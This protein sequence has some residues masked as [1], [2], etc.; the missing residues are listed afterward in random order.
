M[1]S[2]INNYEDSLACNL[3]CAILLLAYLYGMIVEKFISF[4]YSVLNIM[5][6]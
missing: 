4:V 5:H 3:M 1:S 6:D 2:V